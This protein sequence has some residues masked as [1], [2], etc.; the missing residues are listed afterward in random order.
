MRHRS[1]ACLLACLLAWLVWSH[2][3][4]DWLGR[5][6]VGWSCLSKCCFVGWLDALSCINC[7]SRTESLSRES[8]ET[9]SLASSS[10]KLAKP[11][12]HGNQPNEQ[13]NQS[14]YQP[15][16]QPTDQA[17]TQANKQDSTHKHKHTNAFTHTYIHDGYAEAD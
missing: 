7:K 2:R 5:L 15:T 8:P 14:I 9:L 12:P 3:W 11:K 13:T 4:L 10:V 16:D 6:G 17:S 1:P